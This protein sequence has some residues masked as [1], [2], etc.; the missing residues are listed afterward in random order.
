[1]PGSIEP[2]SPAVPKTLIPALPHASLGPPSPPSTAGS[3]AHDLPRCN[4]QPP[5]QLDKV[6]LDPPQGTSEP[7]QPTSIRDRYSEPHP[8]ILK[9]ATH[10]IG[11]NLPPHATLESERADL[12][13]VAFSEPINKHASSSNEDGIRRNYKNRPHIL[14]KAHKAHVQ[15][16]RTKN[17]E[18]LIRTLYEIKQASGYKSDF[19]TFKGYLQY[20]QLVDSLAQRD[21]L[22][23]PRSLTDLRAAAKDSGE[24]RR[25][26]FSYDD[27]TFLER[28]IE[29]ARRTLSGPKP[30][31]PFLPSFEKMKLTQRNKDEAIE[32]RLRS[33]K[34][35][36]LSLPPADEERVNVLLKRK[37]L[38]SKFAKEQV[39]DHDLSRLL[40]GH[41]LNDEIINFYGAMI[42]ARS[43]DAKE[44]KKGRWLNVYYFSTFFWAKLSKEGYEKG[45]LAKWTKKI[46]IFSKDVAL[47]PVNHGN[48][49]WTGA[50]INF[51]HKRIESYDS[52]GY[53]RDEVYRVRQIG[54]VEQEECT[55]RFL[56]LGGLLLTFHATAGERI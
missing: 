23:S 31:P 53:K 22:S 30:P 7:L 55:L 29:K 43:E 27:T 49:H 17:R 9:N 3:K 32:R 20:G 37:G 21:A 1:M 28:A 14:I 8:P 40:P 26:S 11:G 48:A 5:V 6:L 50:V 54:Y 52:M 39:M 25:H 33:S 24:S 47:I 10:E 15:A 19:Q 56:W 4:I 42:M 16:E 34:P 13:S 46:D 36:P 44:N 35:L 12:R 18:E 38:I 51:R 2:L 45:R 41:W